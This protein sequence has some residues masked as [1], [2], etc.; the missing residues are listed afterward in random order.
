MRSAVAAILTILAAPAFPAET[1]PSLAESQ[2]GEAVLA[3]LAAG[4]DPNSA[5]ADGTTA[6]HWAANHGDSALVL[7]LL[8]AGAE[9]GP[10]NAYG[11]SPI[12][13]AAVE[14]DYA[15]IKALL[16]A[17]ADV[18]S[19][20][21]EAQT[22]LMVVARTDQA[23]TARLLLEHGADVNATESFGGQSALMW[24]AAQRQPQMLRLLLAHGA[25]PDI[26]GRFH[27]WERR[28]TAEPRIKIMHSGGFT[29]LLY[30]AREA[31]VECVSVLVDGGADVDLADPDGITPLVLALL[32]RNFDTAGRLIE[33]GADVNRWDWWGRTPLY[34]AVDLDP[35]P[36]SRY[37]DLPSLDRL[38]GLD[39]ARMLLS[40]GANVHARIRQQPPMRAEPGDR[41]YTDGSPDVLVLT[42]GAAALHTA[43]K[44]GNDVA[45]R[46][47]LEYGADVSFPSVFGITPVLAAAGLG[48]WYGLFQ[49]FPTRGRYR[50]GADA[51]VTMQ[52]L[53]DA[54]A[55]INARTSR[56]NFGFQRPN[57]SGLT[58][59][60][61][62][63]FEGWNEVIRFLYDM[64]FDINAAS[65]DGATPRDLAVI[66][67]ETETVALIDELL[68]L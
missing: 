17:G 27:N 63:A 50:T 4:A 38:T 10:I 45:V 65:D 22:V 61:G 39:I 66:Q 58:A 7:A 44:S 51:V 14:S 52:L 26:R 60:H 5:A 9:P 6:L 53:L 56:L 8:D 64:G 30:A 48:H 20:N 13:A 36:N 32:N 18:E 62:A 2:N 47:L 19:P 40:R 43:V 42:T 3:L 68:A 1:L 34:V 16:D 59:A 21:Q 12:A 37:G 57:R 54:G 31:C 15:I 67:E 55:D 11:I 28:V 24:A 49:D 35:V 25:E 23:E 46:L 29:A 33:L 41:G